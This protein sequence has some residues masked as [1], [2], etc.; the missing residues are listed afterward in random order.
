[1]TQEL[2]G[3]VASADTTLT[4]AMVLFDWNGTVVLDADRARASLN[5]VLGTR[6]L[7][8]LAQAE[9]TERFRLP[10]AEMFGELGVAEAELS[11]AEEEW[12]T[13]MRQSTTS[14]RAGS[15]GCLAALSAGGAWLGVVSAA[16]AE[17]VRFDQHS[18]GVDHVWDSV[19]A[20]VADKLSVL[21]RHRGRRRRA[22][23]V[24]D[25]PYDMRCARAAGFVAVG[26]T[27]GYAATSAL[28][29]AGADHLIVSLEELLPI[30]AAS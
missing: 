28:A 15:E 20:P 10:M 27:G 18:L 17:A 9:F 12:N 7:G 25:T 26:V 23:Y 16:A 4:D 22:F 6:R 8:E 14:L 2:P 30:V 29:D 13:A 1:M 21:Q 24:G 5:R 3:V 19:E 11:R